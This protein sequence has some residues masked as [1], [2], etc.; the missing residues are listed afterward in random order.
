MIYIKSKSEIE[1]MKM[2]NKI[3]S[4]M[5]EKLRD[6]LKPGLTTNEVNDFCEE[7]IRSMG[8]VPAQIGYGEPDNPFP[9]ATCTAVNDQVCHAIPSNY[10]LKQGDLLTV[11]TVVEYDGFMGD[12]ASSYH[13]GK[14]SKKVLDL[15]KITKQS[16]YLGI[17]QAVIGN[18]LG[19]IGNAIQS[20]VEAKGYS[21]VREFAGHGIGRD[22]HE[23][24][25]VAHYG[26]PG[27]GIRLQEGMVITIEPMINTGNWR[28][29]IDS[30]GWTARTIDGGLSCQ[31]EHTL[32]ITKDGPMILT[33]Q[34]GEEDYL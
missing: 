10:I 15:M 31:Y 8:G 29:K 17:K 13:I 33:K 19:D 4:S 23:E 3:V 32:A 6:F 2:A 1:R 14:A 18:R 16:L 26:R 11:D 21:V 30:D 25:I 9:A 20:Y 28:C 27:R 5:H 12:S 7:H 24:P 22:M 34:E